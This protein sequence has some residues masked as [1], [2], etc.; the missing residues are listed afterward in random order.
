[1][2][3]LALQHQGA[4]KCLAATQRKC[5]RVA[6]SWTRALVDAVGTAIERRVRRAI[7]EAADELS[8]CDI[9]G[10]RPRSS[11]RH[12]PGADVGT[13]LARM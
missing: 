3:P 10:S 4:S 5:A 9:A 7:V 2:A 13:A 12:G 1:M 8:A 11:Q 6:V